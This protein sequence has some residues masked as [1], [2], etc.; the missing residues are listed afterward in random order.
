MKRTTIEEFQSHLQLRMDKKA[1]EDLSQNINPDV[2]L[3]TMDGEFFGHD[4]VRQSNKL[5][6]KCT[7][8]AA[9]HYL[10]QTVQGEMAFL[11]WSA[12]EDETEV[13]RGADSFL[14]K[15]RKGCYP[16]YLLSV[17]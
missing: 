17:S 8:G 5:L 7:A 10:H 16:D 4:G 2:V 1:E 14:I 15:K 6:E 11:V 13:Y 3:L 12:V 9:Y